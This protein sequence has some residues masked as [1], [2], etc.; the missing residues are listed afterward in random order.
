MSLLVVNNSF[1]FLFFFLNFQKE[2]IEEE[3]QV[4]VGESAEKT[5]KVAAAENE[6]SENPKIL[7]KYPSSY[8]FSTW[9]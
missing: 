7:E 4:K 6:V 8:S 5:T 3:K 1:F 2:R 9:T